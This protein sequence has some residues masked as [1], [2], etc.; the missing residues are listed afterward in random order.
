MYLPLGF[1]LGW[2]FFTVEASPLFRLNDTPWHSVMYFE[3]HS[4]SLE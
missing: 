3:H 1:L 4:Y 2:I